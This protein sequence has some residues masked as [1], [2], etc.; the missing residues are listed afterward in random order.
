MEA[1]TVRESQVELSQA[2]GI[3]ESNLLWINTTLIWHAGEVHPA[4]R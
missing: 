3:Q 4:F 2:M 1:K